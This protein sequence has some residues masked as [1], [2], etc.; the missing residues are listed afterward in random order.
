MASIRGVPRS[1]RRR[2]APTAVVLLPLAAILAAPARA[3]V[4]PIRL[5]YRAYPGCPSESR[6]VEDVTARTGRARP[7]TPAETARTFVVTVTRETGTV[8]GLLSIAS[9]D[10]AVS[11]REVT[12]DTCTEVVA[13]LALITALAIDPL[14]TTAPEG[15][16]EAQAPSIDEAAALAPSAVPP[17]S[18]PAAPTASSPPVP[19]PAEG[20]P[21]TPAPAPIGPPPRAVST[22]A[23]RS[24]N[25]MR[26]AI[27]V[28]NHGLVG[29]VPA[30]GYGGGV[31][32]AVAGT[33]RG[34]LVPS[35]RASLLAAA[36]HVDLT[37]AVGA[38]LEWFVTRLEGC[39]LRFA[40]DPRLALYLCVA[41]DVGVLRSAGSGLPST[42]VDLN[43]WLAPAALAHLTWAALGNLFVEAGGGVTAQATRY[44][45]YFE[46][47]SV[48]GA[49]VNRTPLLAATLDLGVGYRF[50]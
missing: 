26:W 11:R 24:P 46:Q 9:L 48:P 3:D 37:P 28:E 41:V 30:W 20:P 49:P 6:F 16:L 38:D 8:H 31:F 13:A 45:F 50:P 5:T 15:P 29:L 22:D 47:S 43:P 27:G 10:G 34:Y 35:F 25:R 40:W 33:P 17:S 23:P 1:T 44:S 39:P 36:T 14:A 19:P 12:G 18:P 4:E 21:S 7:A 32:V 42:V 2:L